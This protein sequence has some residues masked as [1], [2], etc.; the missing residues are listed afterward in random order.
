[1]SMSQINDLTE[2]Q[3]RLFAADCAER[4][5]ARV[6]PPDPR[7]VAA[8]KAA[9]DFAEGRID[10]DELAGAWAAALAPAWATGRATERAAAWSAAWSAASAAA[11]DAAWDAE[12]E[13]QAQRIDYYLN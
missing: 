6:E 3:A 8:V 9:R 13:W 7:S 12:R 10:S 11:R 1:M 5:L 2:R 4:A